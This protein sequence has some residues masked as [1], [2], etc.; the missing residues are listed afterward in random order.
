MIIFFIKCP[1][2]LVSGFYLSTEKG[3]R[4]GGFRI[5]AGVGTRLLQYSYVLLLLIFCNWY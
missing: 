5:M 4:G 2:E 3:R 1:H